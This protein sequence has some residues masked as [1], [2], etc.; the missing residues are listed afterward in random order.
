MIVAI[1]PT[2]SFDR[3][4]EPIAMKMLI[5]R[6][7]AV[8]EEMVEGLVYASF[9]APAHSWTDGPHREPTQRPCATA[10]SR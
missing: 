1:D 5:N 3:D 2:R 8:V 9:R 10:R 4:A 6:P 7:E